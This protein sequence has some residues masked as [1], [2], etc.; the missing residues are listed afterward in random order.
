MT[1]LTER[2]ASTSELTPSLTPIGP[3]L[4]QRP[5][6]APHEAQGDIMKIGKRAYEYVKTHALRTRDGSTIVALRYETPRGIERT[7]TR[8]FGRPTTRDRGEVA[9][10]D[11]D[12][13]EVAP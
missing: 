11:I 8:L 3:L 9:Y 10:W 12:V 5:R 6:W 1:Q 2:A 7:L 4:R 13:N